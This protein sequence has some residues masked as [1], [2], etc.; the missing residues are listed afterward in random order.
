MLGAS[1]SDNKNS[2]LRIV[3]LVVTISTVVISICA[4]LRG[5]FLDEFFTLAIAKKSLSEM[6]SSGL[7]KYEFWN[8]FPPLYEILVRQSLF[9]GE[10]LRPFFCRLPSIL[11]FGGLALSMF[12]FSSKVFNCK[13]SALFAVI[14]FVLSPA[15]LFFA[16]MARGYVL[17]SFLISLLLVVDYYLIVKYAGRVLLKLCL[18]TSICIL[19]E[20]TYYLGGTIIA[21]NYMVL[22]VYFYRRKKNV[23][24][25]LCLSAVIV[26]VSFVPWLNNFIRDY[27]HE[28]FRGEV[29]SLVYKVIFVFKQVF[30]Q[31]NGS[32][33]VHYIIFLFSTPFIFKRYKKTDVLYVLYIAYLSFFLWMAAYFIMLDGKLDITGFVAIRYVLPPF[34]IV[35]L[36]NSFYLACLYKK[37]KY[38][39]V[40][41]IFFVISSF[42][43]AYLYRPFYKEF[44]ASIRGVSKYLKSQDYSGRRTC[45]FL[46]DLLFASGF[47]YYFSG[48][49]YA[50]KIMNPG[51]SDLYGQGTNKKIFSE[52]NIFLFANII[53]LNRYEYDKIS[54]YDADI[55][56]LVDSSLFGISGVRESDVS[57]PLYNFI[58]YAGNYLKQ[59]ELDYVCTD[60]YDDEG[61]ACA[62]YKKRSLMT[63]KKESE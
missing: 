63:E 61:F 39:A 27:Y 4:C 33:L 50:E 36:M 15:Y 60:Q 53:G 1:L 47:I 57:N 21:A 48:E 55:L 40:F 29:F 37:N 25:Y 8:S 34:F 59:A 3:F 43:D 2:I 49:D 22:A 6:F 14:F 46:E 9:V 7:K 19:I 11:S 56:V 26:M 13:R 44:I 52:D 5:L 62:V 16:Q 28:Q 31:G 45:F 51:Y 42:A 23:L 38:C 17:L 20:Y 24:V 41:V 32:F 35:L 10:P 54:T 18:V 12:F 58:N 30:L